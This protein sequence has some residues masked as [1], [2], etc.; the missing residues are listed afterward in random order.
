MNEHGHPATLRSAQPGNRN[1][2]KTGVYSARARAERAAEIRAAAA[3]VSTF[4]LAV[5]AVRDERSRLDELRKALDADIADHGPSTRAGA[6]REQFAQR[7]SVVRQLRTLDSTWAMGELVDG[8]EIY[9]GMDE[10]PAAG[11]LRDQL[12]GLLALRDLLDLDL[13]HRGVSTQ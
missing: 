1:A 13:E 2:M 5:A 4:E 3:G 10:D 8:A 7:S 9:D 11:A 12:L 6:A